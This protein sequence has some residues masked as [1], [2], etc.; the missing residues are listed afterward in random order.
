MLFGIFVLALTE[1]ASVHARTSM[2]M[3]LQ[4]HAME[5]CSVAAIEVDARVHQMKLEGNRLIFTI[6]PVSA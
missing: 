4:P 2:G 3:T 1:A 6:L 5:E